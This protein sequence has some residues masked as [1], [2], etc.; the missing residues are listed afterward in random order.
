M[1]GE[2]SGND[3]DELDIA[4]LDLRRLTLELEDRG[5]SSREATTAA[6]CTAYGDPVGA[7]PRGRHEA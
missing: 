2:M 1:L 7:Q 6:G 5:R 3:P 4:M